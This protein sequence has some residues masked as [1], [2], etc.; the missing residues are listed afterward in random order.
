MAFLRGLDV[1]LD[2][3][4]AVWDAEDYSEDGRW[5]V[6]KDAGGAGLKQSSLGA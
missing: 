3:L 6:L 5:K 4:L 1:T 2:S